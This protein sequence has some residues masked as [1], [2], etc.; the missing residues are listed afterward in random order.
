MGVTLSRGETA[1]AAAPAPAP[2]AGP[3]GEAPVAGVSFLPVR[4]AVIDHLM[5]AWQARFTAS[6]S[7]AAV[8]LAFADWA[9]HLAN[10]PG[11]QAELADKALRKT[12]RLLAHAATAAAAPEAPW[13]IEPLPGDRRFVHEDWRLFPFSLYAQSFLLMQQWLHNATTAV[14]GVGRA[15]ARIVP[16]VARQILDVFAPSNHPLTNPE[17]VRAAITSG[18]QTFAR[19]AANWLDDAAHL[20]SGRPLPG[21]EAFRVGR[22]LAVTPGQV[23]FRNELF[24]LIQYAPLTGTVHAEPVLIVP[25]WIMKYY[26][27]DLSPENSLVRFLVGNGFTVFA[28][29]WRN[30]GAEQRDLGLDD[31][32]RLGVMAA[33]D[34][35]QA[36]CGA[37]PVHACGYCL[38]GTLLAIAAAAMAR[39]GDARLATVTLLA[40]QTDF[41][42]AGELML[43][44][45]ESQV[46]YLEDAMWES[47]YLDVNQMAGAFQMLR[48][49]DLIWSRLVSHYLRGER[50]AVT[51]LMAWNADGTRLPYR[52]HS[53]YLRSLLLDNDLAE[54]RYRVD[55]RAVAL[56]DIRVP[57]FAVGTERDHVA[58]WRSVYKIHILSDTAVTFLLTSSGHNTGIAAGPERPDRSYRIAERGPDA[59]YLDPDTWM[60]TT[61]AR[62]GSWW[63][64]WTDWLARRS[65]AEVAARA[66]AGAPERGYPPLDPAP[67]TYVFDR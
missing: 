24:E 14:P 41:T 12:L 60:A 48:S 11:K 31:Y 36:I 47:G 6:I 29:S 2:A 62:R 50:P 33:L 3:D 63:P 42:E 25:A 16:F 5:H 4:G 30:P 66:A 53:Q 10:A 22:E 37:A 15:N 49:N 57:I 17:V 18:G 8:A 9:V 26:I 1:P 43:F 44:V 7:P 27:L 23:V 65:S 58:P 21:F 20:A 28:M 46:A 56:T 45:N 39:D 40:A 32:R 13:C 52:M 64:A 54:G 59:R 51:D 35:V 61:P 19:G 67:G 38:G 34:A 55:G